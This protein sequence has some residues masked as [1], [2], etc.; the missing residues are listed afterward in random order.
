MPCQGSW[1]Q[2]LANADTSNRSRV[3]RTSPSYAGTISR[4]ASAAVTT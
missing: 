2:V 1:L 4:T 3:N